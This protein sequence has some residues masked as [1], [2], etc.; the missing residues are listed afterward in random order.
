MKDHFFSIKGQ[1]VLI[2]IVLGIGLSCVR[3]VRSAEGDAQ[4]LKLKIDRVSLFKNGLGF[5]S[6]SAVLPAQARVLRLGQLPVPSYG[7]FWLGYSGKVNPRSVITS[8]ETSDFQ[9]GVQNLGQ[10]LLLNAGR[11]AVIQTLPGEKIEGIVMRPRAET[12]PPDVAGPY[13]MDYRRA[14]DTYL[15][16]GNQSQVGVLFI[17]TGKGIVAINAS[18]ISRVDV[19]GDETITSFSVKRKQPAIR[20]ELER[21]AVGETIE[22]SYL[23]RGVTWEPSYLIDLSD[24]KTAKVSA[25]A[26]IVNELADFENVKLEL[27]TGYPNIKFGEVLSPVAMSQSLADFLNS[28]AQ[29]RTDG[30]GRGNSLMQQQAVMVNTASFYDES[31]ATPSYSTAAEG[32]TSED[33]F[34]YPV[35]NFSLRKGDTAWIPLFTAEMP[36]LHL[37]TWKIPDSLDREER[38]QSNPQSGTEP[39]AEEVWHSC[40]LTNT[41]KM[42]LTTAAAQFVTNR[43]FTGQDTCYYT[44]PG[45][46]TTIR[47][48]R[49]MNVL[50]DQAEI[51]LE[52]KRNAAEFYSWR[53]DLVKVK[54]ELKV[55][56]RLDKAAGMEIVKELSGEVLEMTPSAKDVPTAK[57]LKQVNPKHVLTWRIEL[58]PGEE[59]SLNY[60]YQVYIRN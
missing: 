18:S 43:Q 39:K 2:S 46:E 20:I 19:D 27:V 59:V 42:P 6:S 26:V 25:N 24:P 15:P 1:F 60:T 14:G 7:T 3:I 31:A 50:A 44:A 35:G 28:L 9:T 22:A 11:K 13:V 40:R 4:N 29:G 10:Y 12:P 33:L 16:A 36:Y 51:E 55:K 52:R 45:A 32:M 53:Y 23:A 37:Y 8:L 47:I 17:N 49:A 21:P 57:G 30:R 48:N 41:L 5:V 58:K 38:Y 54:G 34:L 56:N